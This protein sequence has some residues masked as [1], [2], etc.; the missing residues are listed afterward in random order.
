MM[1]VLVALVG[2]LC[3]IPSKASSD[4]TGIHLLNGIPVM[5]GSLNSARRDIQKQLENGAQVL[6]FSI[7][8]KVE[9]GG[10]RYGIELKDNP[11][12]YRLASVLK[13]VNDFAT[14]ADVVVGVIVTWSPSVAS[15]LVHVAQEMLKLE[16]VEAGLGN[17][18][19]NDGGKIVVF[20]KG[21]LGIDGIVDVSSWIVTPTTEG[22]VLE[23]I[24]MS[25]PESRGFKTQVLEVS[26]SNW[27][28]K[29]GQKLTQLQYTHE[30]KNLGII[31]ISTD[32]FNKKLAWPLKSLPIDSGNWL[33]SFPVNM[34]LK[35]MSALFG[36]MNSAAIPS[37]Q[38]HSIGEQ[39]ELGMRVLDIEFE[40]KA[41]RRGFGLLS[42]KSSEV[43]IKGSSLTLA[44]VLEQIEKFLAKPERQTEFIFLILRGNAG[45]S[46]GATFIKDALIKSR[47]SFVKDAVNVNTL[48]GTLR[49]KVILVSDLQLST[50]NTFHTLSFHESVVVE[51]KAPGSGET[52]MRGVME[53]VEKIH[54]TKWLSVVALDQWPEPGHLTSTGSEVN[55]N[56]LIQT[57][58]KP[59]QASMAGI[60][61]VLMNHYNVDKKKFDAMLARIV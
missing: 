11:V 4:G 38:A 56:F 47:L 42:P 21:D 31:L 51:H 12:K 39:L 3:S 44:K 26:D 49:G 35:S 33:A 5:I 16:F 25:S 19:E 1:I 54:A 58:K 57:F 7:E 52:I 17:L 27:N 50:P 23:H 13:K 10:A 45:V 14:Q 37:N 53:E 18:G 48:I 30:L 43:V 20:S 2:F 28:A 46:E 60:R 40:T 41:I 24:A 15:K 32:S 9:G 55:N 8:L 34:P 6:N 29:V 22:K 59:P 36:T 61:I